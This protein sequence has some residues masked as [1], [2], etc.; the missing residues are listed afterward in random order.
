MSSRILEKTETREKARR[1]RQ[2]V[3]GRILIGHVPRRAPVQPLVLTHI[4][5]VRWANRAIV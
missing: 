4:H 3:S 5:F 2:I 1:V